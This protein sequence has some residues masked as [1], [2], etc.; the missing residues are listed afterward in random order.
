MT[1]SNLDTLNKNNLDSAVEI[2]MIQE[3]ID[4]TLLLLLIKHQNGH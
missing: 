2:V 3:L 1:H 4:S